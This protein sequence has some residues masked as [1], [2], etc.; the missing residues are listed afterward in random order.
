MLSTFAGWTSNLRPPPTNTTKTP[1]VNN[2]LVCVCA[3]GFYPQLTPPAPHLVLRNSVTETYTT[4]NR[5]AVQFVH[6]L[7]RTLRVRRPGAF[8]LGENRETGCFKQKHRLPPSSLFLFRKTKP[9]FFCAETT[10]AGCLKQKTD[11]LLPFFCFARQNL[12]FLRR[13]QK[14]RMSQIKTD[15]LLPP[16]FFFPQDKTIFLDH[17]SRMSQTKK[18]TTPPAETH[19]T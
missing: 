15:C 18:L 16:P 2:P 5:R 12:F 17:T 14:S 1:I 9:F 11:C 10:K 8:F 7:A 3:P 6:T 13:N 4:S 19:K